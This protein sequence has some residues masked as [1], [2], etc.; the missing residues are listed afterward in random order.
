MHEQT[1]ETTLSL[2]I[3]HFSY[4]FQVLS[5]QKFLNICILKQY[6]K[7]DDQIINMWISTKMN[8]NNNIISK[9]SLESLHQREF[10][11]QSSQQWVV[12]ASHCHERLTNIKVGW[13]EKNGREM[14]WNG[15]AKAPEMDFPSTGFL[16]SSASFFLSSFG[17]FI[18]EET[19]CF[20]SFLNDSP[21]NWPIKTLL[22]A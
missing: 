10:G 1:K 12:L 18:L 7:M 17:F 4:S 8:N 20:L 15:L 19:K 6:I 11:F 2:Y 13:K 14:D 9:D 22:C 3:T 21:I 16:L 5:I